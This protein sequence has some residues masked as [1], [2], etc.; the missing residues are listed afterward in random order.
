MSKVLVIPDVHLKPWMFEQATDIME[1]T[2]V[3]NAVFL[4]DLVDDWRMQDNVE[5]YRETLDAAIDFAAHY[6][7]SMWCYGN[8]DL[9][10]LWNQYDHPGYS[11]AAAD[12]V[13]NKF[14]E[15]RDVL[16]EPR[17]WESYIVWIVYCSATRGFLR[18][19]WKHSYINTGMIST[20]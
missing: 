13:C 16:Y 11:F 7:H 2:D 17:I 12:L 14:E 19:L 10:Y 9:S 4:G 1:N 20:A 3:D 5:L 6:P 18:N 8:H 15:L